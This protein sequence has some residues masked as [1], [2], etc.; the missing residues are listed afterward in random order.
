[1]G[2]F[3]FFFVGLMFLASCSSL[4]LD[5]IWVHDFVASL[6]QEDKPSKLGVWRE[7]LGLEG[8]HEQ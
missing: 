5:D 8:A 3:L 4:I 2:A 6:A 7:S 1:M